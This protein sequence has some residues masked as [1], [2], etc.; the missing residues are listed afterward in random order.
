WLA[1]LS[2]LVPRQRWGEI[3]PVTP[4]TLVVWHRRLVSWKWDYTARRQPGRP[5]TATAIKKLV[6]RMATENPT[7]GHRRV[8]GELVRLGHRIAA[9]TVWQILHDASLDP[10]P[11]RSGPTWRQ[12]LKCAGQGRFGGGL[13][14]RGHRVAYPTLCADRGRARFPPGAS[15]RRDRASDRGVDYSSC[16]QPHDGHRRPGHHDQVPAPGPRLPVHRGV[17]CGLRCGRHPDPYQSTRS[18]PGERD[19]RTNDRN[20]APRTARQDPGRQPPP[21]TSD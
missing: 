3:F 20:S 13:R 4:A 6:I 12:F 15:A 14:A 21:P 1:A 9:S 19:L 11:R 18:T 16:P 17:R 10:A 5:P 8:Q 7:W 2:R